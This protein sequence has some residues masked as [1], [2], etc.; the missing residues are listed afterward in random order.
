MDPS[1]VQHNRDQLGRRAEKE[2]LK[3]A[4]SDTHQSSTK[5]GSQFS[6]SLFKSEQEALTPPFTTTTS[7]DFMTQQ[8]QQSSAFTPPSYLNGGNG[9]MPSQFTSSSSS[10]LNVS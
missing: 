6:P 5:D 9:E 1:T 3:R 2:T 7:H 4:N 10:S 8:H